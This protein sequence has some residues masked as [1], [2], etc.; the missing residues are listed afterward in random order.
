MKYYIYAPSY[1]ENSGGCVVL[2]RLCHI[3]NSIED[4]EAFLV[5]RVPE[6]LCITNIKTFISDIRSISKYGLLKIFRKKFLTNKNWNT[7]VIQKRKIKDIND[8]II[9]YPE[10]TYG[11][12]LNGKNVVRWF[13]HQPGYF[14]K[15][16]N[17]GINELHYK[18][19]SAIKNFEHC[20]S[21]Q[22]ALE[23][24]V[25]YYPLEYYNL[26]NITERSGCCHA[27]RKG[28]HKKKC[29]PNDSIL[30]D[31]LSHKQVSEIFKKSK[32]FISYDDYTAYSL[33][34]ALCG[35]ESI[36]VPDDNVTK[37]QWYPLESDRYGIAYGFE[38]NEIETANN[39]RE[40]VLEHVLNEHNRTNN[41]VIKFIEE[42]KEYFFP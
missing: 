37:E 10:I 4:C 2:H 30:I 23:L 11:N 9:V 17:F 32:R 26:E 12:P 41:N 7:P 40:K 14:T 16:I 24:K 35:C 28:K 6:K 39:T 22:S 8:S 19:N 36:V 15:E 13:L 27:I 18:F 29:H 38:E 21:K 31:N 34:A 20:L 1:N 3:I 33:F 42:T 25:I 5:P